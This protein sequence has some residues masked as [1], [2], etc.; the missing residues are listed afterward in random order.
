MNKLNYS[1]ILVV[2]LLVGSCKPSENH[3]SLSFTLSNPGPVSYTNHTFEFHLDTSLFDKTNMLEKWHVFSEDKILPS[4]WIRANEKNSFHRLFVQTDLPA[5]SKIELTLKPLSNTDTSIASLKST[6][7]EL[8]YKTGGCFENN[9]YTGGEFKSFQSLRV[10]DECTD[11]SFY[12]K[13]E[14]PG[15]E[16]DKVGYRL[17]LDWRNAI[18]IFGK[19]VNDMVLP[20]VGMDG[21]ESY[22]EISDWGMDILKVG[23]SLGI[24][25]V[26]YWDGKNA[27]RV[28][29]TDSVICE[30]TADE[31]LYSEIVIDYYG[32]KVADK[33][34]DLQASLSITA[35]SRATHQQITCNKNLDNLCT[36]IVKLEKTR[37]FSGDSTLA[38]NYLATWG[39]QSLAGDSLGMAVIFQ[40]K[41]LQKITEDEYSYVIVL[42]PENKIVDYYFLAAWEQ[43]PEGIKNY[44]DFKKYLDDY[45]TSLSYPVEIDYTKK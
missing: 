29:E 10:P 24:G 22:H 6:H 35:G 4:Q 3:K 42:T 44:K 14:G 8:W 36:G 33:S 30:I 1:I 40:Q 38:W 20:Q 11:H 31:D 18:D 27:E 43:E 32:W 13:Y 28:A 45:T 41:K 15:W 26:G 16:S 12:I 37:V 21:Y 17:Y 9:V 7:A 34:V 39:E 19:K 23:S 2:I 5:N 25:T